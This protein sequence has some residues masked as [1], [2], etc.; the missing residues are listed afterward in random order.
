M[1][2]IKI[3]RQ[4]DYLIFSG[5]GNPQNFEFLLRK[6]KFKILKKI[7]FPDHYDFNDKEI[8][9]IKYTAKK[10]KP[11]K[12]FRINDKQELEYLDR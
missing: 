3:N 10:N 9:E 1:E 8:K 4:N 2:N 5:I 6:N 7:E 11:S 12:L